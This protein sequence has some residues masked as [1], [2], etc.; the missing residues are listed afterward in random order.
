ML[1]LLPELIA[2][3]HLPPQLFLE[4]IYIV[5]FLRR[6]G[7]NGPVS[8][9]FVPHCWKS[10]YAILVPGESSSLDSSASMDNGTKDCQP[11]HVPR[12]FV[13]AL[14]DFPIYLT[15]RKWRINYFREQSFTEFGLTLG[16]HQ[17]AKY[18]NWSDGK[19]QPS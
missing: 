6:E 10:F 19:T 12:S 9:W 2:K 7:E 17:S 8:G 14:I 3:S 5:F 16:L 11:S 4:A 18:S 1:R 13:S 15:R